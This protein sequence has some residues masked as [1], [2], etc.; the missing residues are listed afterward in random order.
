MQD[1]IAHDVNAKGSVN[2][3]KRELSRTPK[4]FAQEGQSSSDNL[5]V[6]VENDIIKE[7]KKPEELNK[8]QRG[9]NVIERDENGKFSERYVKTAVIKINFI[10]KGGERAEIIG[11]AV[12]AITTYYDKDGNVLRS[13]YNTIYWEDASPKKSNSTSM[14]PSSSPK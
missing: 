1:Y 4:Q 5:I 11:D 13:N 10:L 2:I 3:E 12:A 6:I 14:Q 7:K 8:Y 9:F